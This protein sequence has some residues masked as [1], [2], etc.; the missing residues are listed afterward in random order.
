MLNKHSIRF[1]QEAWVG[2]QRKEL[3]SL[4]P[5]MQK[6]LLGLGFR[7]YEVREVFRDPVVFQQIKPA[8]YSLLIAVIVVDH[9]IPT[10]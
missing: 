3:K 10:F 7:Q 2:V 8:V 6:R 4:V 5:C 9:L 1:I